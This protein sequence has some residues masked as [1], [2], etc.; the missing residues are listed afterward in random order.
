MGGPDITKTLSEIRVDVIK[1]FHEMAISHLADLH[2]KWR[3]VRCKL[4]KYT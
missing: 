4:Q 3:Q 2:R 1:T